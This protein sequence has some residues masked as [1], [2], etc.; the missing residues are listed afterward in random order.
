MPSR[1]P[2]RRAARGTRDRTPVWQWE[3]VTHPVAPVIEVEQLTRTFGEITAVDHISFGV[4]EG[5]IFGFLG[6]N[7]AGKS[8][9]IQILATL[10][11]PTSGTARLAGFDVQRQAMEVRRQIGIVFQDPSLDHRLTAEENLRFHARLYGVPADIYR[12]RSDEVLEM[13]GLKERRH[14]LVWTFSG[15]MKRRLEIARALLH[16]PRVLFLD[17]PTVGLDPQTRAAI[18]D[19]VKHLREDT[20][21][22]IFMTTHYLDEAEHCDRIAIM[23]HGKIVALDTPAALKRG[24]G[25]DVIYLRGPD[26]PSLAAHLQRDFGLE[27]EQADNRLVVRTADAA[28]LAPRILVAVGRGVESLEI[29]QPTLD[30]VFLSLTGRAIRDQEASDGDAFR[31]HARLWRERR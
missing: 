13:M 30:D 11:P 3:K 25:G 22:T 23:D 2:A 24:L 18:W 7:G 12:K 20:G 16:R 29:K 9:T 28:S 17:E 4:E 1:R 5:E 19:Y 14:S 6:P 8:T 10:L 26:L 27:A 31:A 21:V 15:G